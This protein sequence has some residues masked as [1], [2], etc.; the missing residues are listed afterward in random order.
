MDWEKIFT[1]GSPI[2]IAIISSGIAYFQAVRVGNNRIQEVEKQSQIELEKIRE[3]HKIELEKIRESHK[4]DLEK[5]QIEMETQAKLYEQNKQSDLV[6]NATS[7]LMKDFMGNPAIKDILG[8][9]ILKGLLKKT[10]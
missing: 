8:Q 1:I 6:A 2:I 4:N 5:I 10:E 3:S 7:D 9:E